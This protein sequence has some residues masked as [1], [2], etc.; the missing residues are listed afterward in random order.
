MIGILSWEDQ[1]SP[2]FHP[3]DMQTTGKARTTPS[4]SPDCMYWQIVSNTSMS[5]SIDR[6][7]EE[8]ETHILVG[9]FFLCKL[10]QHKPRSIPS[11]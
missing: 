4:R 2:T 6:L 5:T 3:H 11:S 1:Y 10:Y 9:L 7:V 8:T